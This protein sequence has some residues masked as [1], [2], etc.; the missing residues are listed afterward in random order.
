MIPMQLLQSLLFVNGYLGF[1]MVQL[2]TTLSIKVIHKGDIWGTGSQ[3]LDTNGN[4][5]GGM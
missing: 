3:I 5:G 2:E 1:I 4:H